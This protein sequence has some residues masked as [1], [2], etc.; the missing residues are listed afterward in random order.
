MEDSTTV[1]SIAA[2]FQLAA[3]THLCERTDRALAKWT[4]SETPG[5]ALAVVGGV[6]RN[7]SIRERLSVRPG[8]K[9][10]TKFTQ[11]ILLFAAQS[12]CVCC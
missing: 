10:E 4:T 11:T 8:S 12:Y 2:A 3:V 7:T 9:E 1:G 5:K 6:A